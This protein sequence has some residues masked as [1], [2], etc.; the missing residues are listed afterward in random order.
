MGDRRDGGAS[1]GGGWWCDGGAASSVG[2]RD[3]RSVAAKEMRKDRGR[4]EPEVE[5]G[6]QPGR[7][8]DPVAHYADPFFLMAF[9]VHTIRCPCMIREPNLFR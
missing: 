2:G 9:G 4:R 1:S 6:Q 8:A 5:V 7:R 3:W